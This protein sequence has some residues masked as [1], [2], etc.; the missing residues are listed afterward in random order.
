MSIT[1]TEASR[2]V[3]A[4]FSAA[5][6]AGIKVAIAVL[7]ERGDTVLHTRMDGSR[8]WWLDACRA[9]AFASA[10]FGQPSGALTEIAG[11]PMGQAL[12]VMHGGRIACSQGALP[13]MRDGQLIGAV[14]VGGGTGQQDEDVARAGVAVL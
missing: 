9:K 6:E 2:I 7:D 4:A 10:I 11:R 5:S 3:D 1:Y 13:L 12:L 14:G 8:W